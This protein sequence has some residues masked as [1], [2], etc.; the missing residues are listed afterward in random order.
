MLPVDERVKRPKF[1][2]FKYAFWFVLIV[3]VLFWLFLL[4][5]QKFLQ[6]QTRKNTGI[7]SLSGIDSLYTVEL[8]NVDQWVLVRGENRANPLMLVLHGGP[9]APLFPFARDLGYDTSL[10]EHFTMIY[11]EQRGTGKSFHGSIAPGSMS[12]QQMVSDALDLAGY[13]REQFQVSKIYLLA[14]SWGSLLGIR[15]IEQKPAWFYAYI[16]IGQIVTPLRGDSISFEYTHKLAIDQNEVEALIALE[17][18]GFPPYD[19][20]ELLLQRR[21]LSRLVKKAGEASGNQG[22][23]GLFHYFN[24]LLATPEYSLWDILKM[25]SDPY[26][27]LK[28]LWNS[29][30]YE[31]DLRKDSQEINV[32]VVFIC[33]RLDYITPAII[34]EE[35][36]Q[37]LVAPQGKYFYWFEKSGHQPEYNESRKFY[38]TLVKGVLPGTYFP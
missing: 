19:Y 4:T 38:D 17:E 12:L 3:F 32:P 22:N 14:R 15:I 20:Q 24:K 37:N 6:Y 13:L 18:T 1:Y 21:L 5:Y 28:Y 34:V 29:E 35:Y 27:S 26:F 25:G 23:E 31:I 11:W 9:G 33:G 30:L 2:L 16:S 8:G 10:E 7:T 36:Y